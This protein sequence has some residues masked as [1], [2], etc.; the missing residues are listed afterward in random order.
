M[1]TIIKKGEPQAGQWRSVGHGCKEIGRKKILNTNL[2]SS[3][4]IM[5]EADQCL[6]LEELLTVVGTLDLV[7]LQ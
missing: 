6:L 3:T 2:L 1:V 7:N 5:T 4:L